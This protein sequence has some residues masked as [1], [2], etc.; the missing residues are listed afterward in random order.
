MH[1]QRIA[2]AVTA[3]LGALCTFVPWLEDVPWRGTMY[4]TE[5]EGGLRIMLL[6]LA[7]AGG[8][9]IGKRTGPLTPGG[10]GLCRLAGAGIVLFA[11][12]IFSWSDH[13]GLGSHIGFGPYFLLVVGVAIAVLPNIVKGTTASRKTD[14]PDDR[15]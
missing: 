1:Q 8:M 6:C 9:F 12:Y 3:V 5:V 11:I 7:V 15:R 10:Y 4:G 13:I 2:I 14:Q